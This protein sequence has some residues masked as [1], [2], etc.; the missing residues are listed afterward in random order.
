MCSLNLVGQVQDARSS[1]QNVP[2]QSET[3][4]EKGPGQNDDLDH[5]YAVGK[6]YEKFS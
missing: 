6:S 1:F 2:M 4:A 5:S 3:R